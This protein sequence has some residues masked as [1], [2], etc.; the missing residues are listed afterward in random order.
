MT[1]HIHQLT[2]ARVVTRTTM[3]AL[4]AMTLLAGCGGGAETTTN[5][6]QRQTS[7][8]NYEGPDPATDDVQAFRINL[9]ENVRSS[10]RCGACH[11]E[12][13][14]VPTFANSADVNQ[15]YGA[16]NTV[17]NLD[18]P[19]DSTMVTKVAEGHN[20]WLDSDQ[21]CADLIEQYIINWAGGSGGATTR[22]QLEA[23]DLRDP[24]DSLQFPQDPSAFAST[25][26]PLLTQHCSDCHRAD[27]PVRQEQPYFAQDDVAAA[28]EAVQGK[29][30]LN[31]PA[32]SRLVMRL[33]GD[34]HNCWSV[35]E[36]DA[37]AMQSAI[38]SLAG[39]I[40]PTEVDPALVTSQ[41]LT[42][43]DGLVASAGGRYEGNVIA[44]Y[45]FKTG[46]G[47]TVYDTSGVEPQLN[48]ILS[49]D[50]GWVGGYGI[51]LEGGKAQARST[52]SSKLADLIG[53][54]GEYSVEAWVV[55]ANVSQEGPA[56]IVSYSG[57]ND[58]RNF[59]LGQTLYNY[60]FLNRSDATGGNG[61]PAVS[62]PDGDEVLQA[63]LQHVVLTY[64]PVNGRR[65]YVNGEL[66]SEADMQAGGS[67]AGWND[68]YALVL[69]SETSNEFEWQGTVRLLA[70]YNRALDESQINQ[71]FDA[72]VGQKFYLLFHVGQLLTNDPDDIAYRSYI[73]TE[74]S[75]FDGYS[76]LF[77]R[78]HFVNLDPN[79]APP[80]IDIEGM[81]I[82]INGQ[83]AQVGQAFANM[84]VTV[85]AN[86]YD[87]ESLGQ[88]LSR[89]GTTIGLQQGPETDEFF[90]TFDRFGTETFV[91]T[92]PAVPTPA[93]PTDGDPQ[94][95]IGLRTF[96]EVDATMA[97]VTGVSRTNT[98]VSDTFDRVK[99]QLPTDE[100]IRGFLSAHQVGV[101]QLAIEYC[102]ELV[103]DNGLRSD[104]FGSYDFGQPASTAFD[105][106]AQKDA[107]IDPIINRVVGSNLATQPDLTAV[108][109]ELRG[110]IDR[111][112]TRCESDSQCMADAGRTQ[113]IAKASCAA[114]LG[115]AAML[116][117]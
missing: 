104:F 74:V 73:L 8:S 67:L 79:Y 114:A 59:T 32:S 91:R 107:L 70:I 117:Q 65:I 109:T 103:N 34:F 29:I 36:D 112:V 40:Q 46:A 106:D 95:V 76:Y 31:D 52:N 26:H 48:L 3:I 97:T 98:N 75:R 35:C 99:Q 81:R 105:S 92:P 77:D 88:Q 96:D 19:E 20:C 64:D 90:L 21:A 42:L 69:G 110:L 55:P 13:G 24:G 12:N 14:Q 16:V 23:P 57:G 93:A 63:T 68:T 30:N 51:R 78:P 54:T 17:V 6:A 66:A 7:A 38:E 18:S 41:A 111:L 61:M 102:N 82:G 28:Y 56:R 83:E 86:E 39:G 43:G 2:L 87:Y 84:D 4:L 100:N 62:T 44:F 33:R 27:G 71:N 113:T 9:W 72:G 94:S 37:D 49:G 11:D 60:D 115:S 85:T 22:V 1:G 89:M 45:E 47:T 80:D 116:I 53:A 10:A 5:P 15:A 108:R 50:Y 101:S 25:V 58:S